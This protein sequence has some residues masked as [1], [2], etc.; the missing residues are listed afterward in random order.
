MRR[1]CSAR[2]GGARRLGVG[3]ASRPRDRRPTTRPATG[4]PGRAVRA[5]CGRRTPAASH[6]RPGGTMST[7]AE[8]FDAIPVQA[9]QQCGAHPQPADPAA[10]VV[11]DAAA[12]LAHAARLLEHV[13]GTPLGR[14]R[15]ASDRARATTALAEECRATA[16]AMA[17]GVGSA[18]RLCQPMA[19]A[20]DQAAVQRPRPN[21]DERWA[22]TTA[23]LTP[24]QACAAVLREHAPSPDLIRLGLP[25]RF[26]TPA[27]IGSGP[28]WRMGNVRTAQEVFARV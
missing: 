19:G 13:G 1:R 14:G 11:T 10:D 25:P 18:G 23:A 4:C 8:L 26:R 9:W 2:W 3:S 22:I 16:Q 20:A 5:A 6:P 17:T 21:S 28:E 7:L 15:Y 24:I 27:L 12:A